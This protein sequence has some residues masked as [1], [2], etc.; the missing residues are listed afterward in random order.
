MRL[1]QQ[2]NRQGIER[3][4]DADGKIFFG[5]SGFSLCNDFVRVDIVGDRIRVR[6]AGVDADSDH[7][8]LAFVLQR[9]ENSAHLIEHAGFGSYD[10]LV[11]GVNNRFGRIQFRV[12]IHRESN[13]HAAWR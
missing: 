5:C 6:S 4:T 3:R 7:A 1:R 9:A 12:I 8:A 2:L 10:D 11:A 13:D